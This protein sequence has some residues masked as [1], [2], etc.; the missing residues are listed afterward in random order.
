MTRDPTPSE[1]AA[2]CAE[3]QR[4]K[5]LCNRCHRRNVELIADP[6]GGWVCAECRGIEEAV[7]EFDTEGDE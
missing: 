4:E 2:A 6:H 5:R 1:I 3:I 7:G